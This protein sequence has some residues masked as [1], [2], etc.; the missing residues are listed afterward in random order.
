MRHAL[1]LV[2]LFASVGACS[3]PQV[4]YGPDADSGSDGSSGSMSS[5]GGA[6]GSIESSI[7]DASGDS[8]GSFGDAPTDIATSDRPSS[9]SSGDG[10]VDCDQDHD[11]FKGPQCGGNDCC[12]T[13]SN[14]HPNQKMFFPMQDACKSW[15][16]NCD[17]TIEYE[18]PQTIPCTGTPTLGC[19]GGPGFL[20]SED[21]GQSGPYGSCQ[22]N[23]ALA[24][25]LKQTGTD[26][27][28]CQ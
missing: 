27:Q 2:L 23:G 11:N 14:A 6:D 18:F 7:G 15:D 5:G 28:G 12:D 9:S 26:T 8:S 20:G 4:G 25:S 19:N 16:Y 22:P 17:M 1:P 21:C 24:C 10:S 3:F 13:D